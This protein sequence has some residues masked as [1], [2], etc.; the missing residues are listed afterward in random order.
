MK[1][2]A[3]TIAAGAVFCAASVLFEHVAFAG[4]ATN[5]TIGG[6]TVRVFVPSQP[7][8]KPSLV[9]MLHGCT[10]NA[11]DFAAATRMDDVAEANGFVVAYPQQDKLGTNGCWQWYST[12]HQSRDAGEPKE[13]ADIAQ[14]VATAHGV[15]ADRVYVAGIS[16]GGAMSVVLG[17]T[18]P[19]RFAAIGVVA[20]LEYKAATSYAGSFSATV[21]GGP[22]PDT[23]GTL[24][25]TAMGSFARVVPTLVINGTSDGVVAPINGDQVT[26][27]WRK[28][29]ELV[30]GDGS[31]ADPTSDTGMAGYTF[32]RYLHHEKKNNAVVVEQIVVD[33]LGHAWPGGLANGSYSDPK[34]PDASRTLWDFFKARST[35]T[36]LPP[37]SGDP[38]PVPG[39][40]AGTDP[41][42]NSGGSSGNGA[43]TERTAPTDSPAASSSDDGGCATTPSRGTSVGGAVAPMAMALLAALVTIARRRQRRA[44]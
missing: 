33:G 18:Y 19:D 32:T 42:T 41:G 22:D 39:S 38:D 10:Q 20:G 29:N 26:Q 8:A 43:S 17:A 1:H 24:A 34:G 28:T 2:L 23:Q 35:T 11:A 5:E 16:S 4:T 27:Q 6:R 36:P 37:D 9:L 7:D 31:I 21:S 12:A 44:S 3:T 40:D 30:L 15:S 25:H 14:T 13:L